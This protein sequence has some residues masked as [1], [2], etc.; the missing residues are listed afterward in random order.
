MCI[1]VFSNISVSILP[2]VGVSSDIV[3]SNGLFIRAAL[4]LDNTSGS[5]W[6]GDVLSPL[7]AEQCGR[8]T[9]RIVRMNQ[10]TQC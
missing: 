8:C 2:V 5:A 1:Y 10:R 4:R 9:L 3:I 6:H 7:R